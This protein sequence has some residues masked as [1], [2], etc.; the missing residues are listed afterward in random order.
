MMA[1]M[2]AT[3]YGRSMPH[4]ENYIHI[5]KRSPVNPLTAPLAP[6]GPVFGATLKY[7]SKL[8]S[9]LGKVYAKGFPKLALVG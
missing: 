1:M 7:L 8:G 4:N 2:A 9:G 5:S 3:T 6:V